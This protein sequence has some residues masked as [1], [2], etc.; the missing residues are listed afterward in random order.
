MSADPILVIVNFSL[1][2][3]RLAGIMILTPMYSSPNLPES[4]KPWMVF[5]IALI[6][7]MGLPVNSWV[8]DTTE[9]YLL[10][11]TFYEFIVGVLLG[12]CLA[13][14]IEVLNFAGNI[15]STPMGLSIALA[16]DPASEE[17]ST[18][19]GQFNTMFASLL[20]FA[21]NL[22]HAV[23]EGYLASYRALPLG[24]A[25]LPYEAGIVWFTQKF[26]ELFLVSLQI[27]IPLLT[28]LILINFALGVLTRTLPKLNIFMVGIPLQIVVGMVTYTITLS[29]LSLAIQ[30]LFHKGFSDFEPVLRLF[31]P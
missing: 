11:M 17:T 26:Y 22:H 9:L 29:F 14:V 3:A 18:T 19:L 6:V 10:K 5:P 21:M 31:L 12:F 25:V 4:I 13:F 16:I 20:F 28:V 24:Q 2:L 7:F 8:T 30:R 15:V 1:V 27:S 23:L